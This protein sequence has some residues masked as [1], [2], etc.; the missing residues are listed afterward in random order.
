MIDTKQSDWK[1]VLFDETEYWNGLPE[2]CCGVIAGYLIDFSMKVH[3]CSMTGSYEA[4]YVGSEPVMVDDRDSTEAWEFII[5]HDNSEPVEYFS[6]YSDFNYVHD[7][8]R[9]YSYQADT[10][11]EQREEL[12]ESVGANG[13]PQ[14]GF[15]EFDKLYNK[16]QQGNERQ[17]K[18]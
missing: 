15:E 6:E 5:E 10:D 7:I 18:T 12:F 3:I 17:E 13:G 11:E 8:E 16:I 14:Y 4:W 2:G 1:L 9:P